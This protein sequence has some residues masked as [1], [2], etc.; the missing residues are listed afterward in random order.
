MVP[1]P[2]CGWR[3]PGDLAPLVPHGAREDQEEKDAAK[4]EAM[5]SRQR[6]RAGQ[7]RASERANMAG[8]GAEEE[9]DA[10]WSERVEFQVA[11]HC[12]DEL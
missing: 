7:G 1:R 8:A 10:W 2:E 11:L 12:E 6:A 4:L 5:A 9:E 3:M